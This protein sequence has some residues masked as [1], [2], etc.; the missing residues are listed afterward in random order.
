MCLKYSLQEQESGL[1][2]CVIRRRELAM[3][4][5]HH[6]FIINC[7]TGTRLCFTGDPRP[8]P[9]RSRDPSSRAPSTRER[10]RTCFTHCINNESTTDPSCS[11]CPSPKAKDCGK[12]VPISQWQTS[13]VPTEGKPEQSRLYKV[14]E[15]SVKQFLRS[16]ASCLRTQKP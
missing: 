10:L 7:H 13:L 5:I 4:S 8:V 9:V 14:L 1:C 11:C 16:V 12:L 6:T 3:D 2:D 15:D